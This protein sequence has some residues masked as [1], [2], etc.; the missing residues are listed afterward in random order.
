M[1]NKK[2]LVRQWRQEAA[3][4]IDQDE[5]SRFL[6]D[7]KQYGDWMAEGYKNMTY[8]GASD[9]AITNERKRR[10]DE[11]AIRANRVRAW[12]Q[13]DQNSLTPES[14]R[15]VSSYLDDFRKFQED[16]QNSYTHKQKTV[17]RY[18]S[19]EAWSK[20]LR[21]SGYQEKY[22]QMSKQ[23]LNAAAAAL[24]DGEEKQWL[25]DYYGEALR[26][27]ADYDHEIAMINWQLGRLGKVY[28]DFSNTTRWVQDETD[29]QL[30]QKIDRYRENY[31]S[32]Q[33]VKKQM[34]Q[35]QTRRYHLEQGKKYNLIPQNEDFT[36][37][38]KYSGD[39]S[40]LQNMVNNPKTA[41]GE[42]TA[43][44]IFTAA[45]PVVIGGIIDAVSYENVHLMTAEERM[46]FN[47]LHNT[48]G[49]DAAKEYMDWLQYT[50]NQRSAMKL[51]NWV[52]DRTRDIPV[53]SQAW[54]SLASVPLR[55]MG[56]SGILD[57][58]G[59]KVVNA[60]TGDDKPVDYNRDAMMISQASSTVRSSVARQLNDVASIQ[61][62]KEKHPILA[63]WFNGVG[64]GDLYSA[65][66]SM[67]D[68]SVVAAAT[69]INPIAGQVA[70]AL[71]SAS[72]ATDTM[73][74]SAANGATDGQA[75]TA[76]LAAGFFEWFFEKYE[77]ESLMK[78]GKSVRAAMLKQ[79]FNEAVGEG[80]T[81]LCN[82]VTNTWLMA[83]N[84]DWKQ[85]AEEYL[86]Q[87]P[88]LDRSQAENL[89]MMDMIMQVLEAASA[90]FFTGAAMGGAAS[91]I[92]TI[93]FNADLQK[94]YSGAAPQMVSNLLAAD[95]ENALGLKL[96][97]KLS[98]GKELSGAEL[99]K[100]L[101][102]LET[103]EAAGQTDSAVAQLMEG[104]E[105]V[106]K[107]TTP[108][109][110]GSEAIS[111]LVDES[112]A[113]LTGAPTSPVGA[114]LE[115]FRATGTVTN[116][117]ATDI[118]NNAAAVQQLV[119]EAG[120][121]LPETA[122]G[123]RA[124]VK[125]AVSR[126]AQTESIAAE[127]VRDEEAP[128][129]TN[130]QTDISAAKSTEGI[131]TQIRARQEDLNAMEPVAQIQTPKDFSAMDA[132]VNKDAV[133]AAPEGFD[134]YSHLQFEY[135]NKPDRT[136][137]VRDINVPKMDANGQRVSDFA[138][139]LYGNAITSD[140]MVQTME[141]LIAQGAFGA[142]T[143]K[144]DD[145]L[146]NSADRVAKGYINKDGSAS[147]TS[148]TNYLSASIAEGR[149][150]PELLADALVMM[151]KAE[152]EGRFEDAGVIAF[153]ASD[154]TRAGGRI[155]NVAKL[156]QR[157]TPEGQFA[158]RKRAAEKV[159]E[160]VNARRKNG[161]REDIAISEAT[162]QEFLN[163]A[164]AGEA[165]VTDATNAINQGLPFDAEAAA[166]AAIVN[167]V[168]T[169]AQ[170]ASQAGT[171][172]TNTAETE[173]VEEDVAAEDV[174]STE[175]S[176]STSESSQASPD[177]TAET[178]GAENSSAAHT[179]GET[180]PSQENRIYHAIREFV[181]SKTK[182]AP[183]S[184]KKA[185]K[186]LDA[187]K[188][189]YA[190]RADFEEAWNA[191]RR[192]AEMDLADDPVAYDAFRQFLDTG[193]NAQDI[194]DTYD[195]GSVTR[196]A[197]REAAKGA[198]V[199]LSRLVSSSLKDKAAALQ[200]IQDYVAQKYE[201]DG[202]AA[203]QMAHQLQEAFYR[204]LQQ[205][206]LK[207]LRSLFGEKNVKESDTA[208][209]LFAELYNTG[210]F[211]NGA[212]ISREALKKIF[213]HDGLSLSRELLAEYGQVSDARKA[214][215]DRKIIQEIA[216][217]LPTDLRHVL[218]KWRYTSMLANP[219]SHLRNMIGDTGQFVIQ[220]GLKDNLAAL[221]EAG[222][223]KVSGGKIKRTKAILNPASAA[224]RALINDALNDYGT[225]LRNNGEIAKRI[226][227]G[228]KYD[229]VRSE[230]EEVR[231]S[232]KINNP[233]NAVTK[234][235][236][237]GLSG[238]EYVA[239]FNTKALDA[240]DAFFGKHAYA[241]SLAAYMKANG[242]T[243][244]TEEARTYA[245]AQAQQATF[246]DDS[247][248]YKAVSGRVGK[249]AKLVV[250]FVKTPANIT[251]RAV[252]YSPGM[253]LK[254]GYDLIKL[255]CQSGKTDVELNGK[256]MTAAQAIDDLSKGLVGSSMWA[257]GI[258]MAAEGLI[259][260]VGTG[261]EE[262][263]EYQRLMGYKDYSLCIGDTCIDISCLSPAILP[264]FTG[265]AIYESLNNFSED[266]VSLQTVLDS[267][268]S[269]TDP[270]LSSSMLS[271][272]DSFMYAIRSMGDS[273]TTGELA[274]TVGREIVETYVSQFFPSLLR[275]IAAGSDN[276]VRQTYADP[277]NPFSAFAQNI[278]S[279]TPGARDGLKAKYDIWG[280]ELKQDASGGDG[281]LGAIWRTVNPARVA[282]THSTDIDG[283]ILRL[284]SAGYD[285][286]PTASNTK[287][288]T[289]G[290]E[291][292]RM[293]ADEYGTYEQ[294]E[295]QLSFSIAQEMIHSDA[296]KALPD[297]LKAKALN[298]AYSYAA[299]YCKSDAVAGYTPKVDQYLSGMG[300]D[301][302]KLASAIL[303]H[304]DESA[305]T[306]TYNDLTAAGISTKTANYVSDLM[307]GIQPEPDRSS[308]RTIQKLEAI[309][310]DTDLS[311]QDLEAIIPLYLSEGQQERFGT[312]MDRGYS[313]EEFVE[314]YRVVLDKEKGQKK[315]SVI[316]EIA[317]EA[318]LSYGAAKR[319]YEIMTEKT[320]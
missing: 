182:K 137:T 160:E 41:D 103:Q 222:V 183:G 194:M 210:A 16:S 84:S 187:L 229:S 81:E 154:I 316:R 304:T 4:Q 169:M 246:H 30:N 91:A 317:A 133:G 111:D 174:H 301:A 248:I 314:A 17:Q 318:G 54:T 69:A 3:G 273:G 24:P 280:Q 242:L 146:N 179:D 162:E 164:T 298:T 218:G 244:I 172:D 266:E 272:L 270:I 23:D 159:S 299:E 85:K 238:L 226:K 315:P 256:R 293:T 216:D 188:E 310:E 175:K 82:I 22:G 200:S 193:G 136:G 59:Q 14:S 125:E 141:T 130:T 117:Q 72:S 150:S 55:F 217:Q 281:A 45:D 118:L 64:I 129:E 232:W 305:H 44:H 234:G 198:D 10:S 302:V 313:P 83:E 74:Q 186:A 177:P 73:L 255:G 110:P 5:V 28:D 102:A 249:V 66:M 71:L 40:Y 275:R 62:D 191:A 173:S 190:N 155:L 176:T 202:N 213:G 132:A 289:V 76:G 95:P 135:G 221:I 320:A 89:A 57:A 149:Y 239:D 134:T 101:T 283:E 230:V 311:D 251:S 285:A 109:Q 49:E 294:A 261:S 131:R 167:T 105:P 208:K 60:I 18:G 274:G 240:E 27:E 107:G 271:G 37:K 291:K 33:A 306:S 1:S 142:Q 38:A 161:K 225:V 148:F 165:V 171:E 48:Q 219:S 211:E 7:S 126:L 80:A 265:A 264:I 163:V 12:L 115:G 319:L 262:E 21:Q 68:S 295:G 312:A 77:I 119:R 42:D 197:L 94:L 180:A 308:V 184:R 43:K 139:N 100:L 2:S 75:I 237:K 104:I 288:I 243:E 245:I 127:T 195:S 279:G 260:V 20:A 296:Y 56:G 233:S 87:N 144:L 269:F 52:A 120:L 247:L 263:R 13:S 267:V 128:T 36:E 300:K 63:S 151:T 181:K 170:E 277:K 236:D 303:K 35:L 93:R 228:G 67:V 253:I 282:D 65:G 252:E 121:K 278:Q 178:A 223:S 6:T 156:T 32:P 34:E 70:S 39:G 138:A 11:M 286:L 207:R 46:I 284:S 259:R 297:E 19:E 58:A 192:R 227:N 122:S 99:Q 254:F 309:T 185:T 257:V 15:T 152:S 147:L 166:D 158:A 145:V 53:L 47:Y 9:T 25:N 235:I 153:L 8:T 214:A 98:D 90:G 92:N 114:A 79:G 168:N 113:Q 215:V 196:K 212:L 96:E 206:Q 97:K 61:L 204:E 189:F 268:Y 140:T 287:T 220:Y 209:D 50:L 78:Q 241:L 307:E 123:K 86:K 290:G 51:N 112:V 26:S 108:R 205:R 106:N 124:A 224:D 231:R 203:S 276:T 143:M 29:E 199:E 250:P 258:W 201:L 31:G 157:L 292:Y 116:K 88:E